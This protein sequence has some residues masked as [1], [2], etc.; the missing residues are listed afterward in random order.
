MPVQIHVNRQTHLP[1]ERYGG[2]SSRSLISADIVF[3]GRGEN[4]GKF[5]KCKKHFLT[6][7]SERKGW[8]TRASFRH[9][10]LQLVSKDVR[11]HKYTTQVSLLFHVTLILLCVPLKIVEEVCVCVFVSVHRRRTGNTREV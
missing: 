4:I 1:W 6:C 11:P 10:L 3:G 2:P 8:K 7:F 5:L 9:I